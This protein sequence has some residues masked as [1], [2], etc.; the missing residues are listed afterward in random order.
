MTRDEMDQLLFLADMC[1]EERDEAL[2]TLSHAELGL[3]LDAAYEFQ[4]RLESDIIM[5]HIDEGVDP[6]KDA[7]NLMNRIKRL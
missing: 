7:N 6:F 5:K 4:T 1:E 3:L 2:D